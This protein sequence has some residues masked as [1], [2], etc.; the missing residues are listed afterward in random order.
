MTICCS[1]TT[2][3]VLASVDTMGG[4][5]PRSSPH[6][7]DRIEETN[8]RARP[9]ICHTRPV[10]LEPMVRGRD[11]RGSRLSAWWAKAEGD[12]RHLLTHHMLDVAHV[13]GAMWDRLLSER[14]RTW[15]ADAALDREAFMALAGL[16]DIGKASPGF[17]AK[18][19]DL[20][21]GYP[22]LLE[23]RSLEVLLRAGRK[24]PHSI[25]SY[26]TARAILDDASGA[27]PEPL[28]LVLG[29]HHGVFPPPS[30]K[31]RCDP[32]AAGD[33]RWSAARAELWRWIV[34]Q[35]GGPDL[36]ATR[37]NPEV[38]V[39]LTGLIITC[40]WIGS[41]I[42]WFPYDDTPL[43][44][45]AELSRTRAQTALDDLTW[46]RWLPKP[47]RFVER[48]PGFEP[49]PA[50]DAIDELAEEL[51]EPALVIV[52]AETGSGKTEAAW[53]L[54]ARWV[55]RGL[56]SGFYM[57]LPT[58]ATANAM[59]ARVRAFLERVTESEGITAQLLHGWASLDAEF[60]RRLS[61]RPT[62]IYDDAAAVVA[63]RW[64]TYRRRGLLAPIGIG[65]VDQIL[66]AALRTRFTPL[67]ISAVADKVVVVDEVHAYDTYM[68][69]ILDRLLAWL[70]HLRVPV[71]LLSA[72][73]PC[74]RRAELL[75]AYA[76]NS[77]EDAA[78]GY[79]AVTWAAPRGRS[80]TRTVAAASPGRSVR[81]RLAPVDDPDDVRRHVEQAASMSET[82]ANV[83]VVV[84]TVTRAQQIGS[85]LRCLGDR[86]H[87]VH[88]R[89]PFEQRDAAERE[90]ME[91]FGPDTNDRPAGHVVVGTQVLEQS[92]DIDLDVLITDLAP[93]DAILQ[94][95]G[96]VHRHRRSRP[97]GFEEPVVV[98]A[99]FRSGDGPPGL[100][101]GSTYVYSP[102]VLLRTLA[103]LNGPVEIPQDVRRLIDAVYGDDDLS[104][105]W[106]RALEMA[107]ADHVAELDRLA[108]AA[109]LRFV[110]APGEALSLER[111]T[112]PAIDDITPDEGDPTVDERIL[113]VTRLGGPSVDVVI[114]T[115]DRPLPDPLDTAAAET[116][117][118]RSLRLSSPVGLVRALAAQPPPWPDHPLLAYTR[119][120]DLDE[121]GRGVVSGWT[122][123]LD[124]LL[125]LVVEREGKR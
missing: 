8:L 22:E 119:R 7:A 99:G 85:A 37:L 109:R 51:D 123:T 13:A 36:A 31:V 52:E 24:T 87:V 35:L 68:S 86:L 70:G 12:R 50:Q 105:P 120:I 117:L 49:R 76:G 62:P 4:A 74:R 57:A 96:R 47:G 55:E 121:H 40:D 66:M 42:D 3:A 98:V 6:G 93:I 28:A 21:G 53:H 79:P 33:D 82:G 116:I 78:S 90:I 23:P 32:I 59:Y 48:F 34:S 30:A 17:Q 73:L 77:P 115:A 113:A 71:I 97:A 83:L 67:R 39:V 56:A 104:V 60:R 61:I 25:V 95:A 38:A 111:V 44:T 75:A 84:N 14:M 125:G 29:G 9:E 80:G 72:T 2:M 81:F 46:W 118:R 92:L 5:E 69:T 10:W 20:F 15:L 112:D 110:P 41:N 89:M 101:E 63:R 102:W 91:R 108:Q 100:P 65:T 26:H 18:R 11:V 27:A 43:D 58:R 1:S 16:H 19:P 103:V 107:E 94:R 106:P 122:V 64:F 45:Y 114:A 88:A 54:A 124:P